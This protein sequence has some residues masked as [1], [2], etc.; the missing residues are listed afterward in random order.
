MKMTFTFV[1][2]GGGEG[3][4]SLEFDLP[5]V[6]QVGEYILIQ[7]GEDSGTEDFIVRRTWWGLKIDEK[8][9]VGTF[10]QL[11]VECEFARG[12]HSSE[13]HKKACD[14]YDVRGKPPK[15]FEMTAY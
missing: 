13:D 10:E 15:N 8:Q 6:P 4:Y 3:D 12:H 9:S 5:N 11:Q 14:M 1:P 7:R 2:P